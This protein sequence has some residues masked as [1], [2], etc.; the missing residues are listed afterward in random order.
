MFHSYAS[1]LDVWRVASAKS[2]TFQQPIGNFTQAAT[3]MRSVV[4]QQ[5]SGIDKRKQGHYW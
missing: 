2:L 4:D 1:S 3:A 5:N